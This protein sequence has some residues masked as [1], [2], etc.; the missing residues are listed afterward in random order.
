MKLARQF[1][2]LAVMLGIYASTGTARAADVPLR[3]GEHPTF[4]RVVFDWESTPDYTVERRDGQ[5]LIIFK[6]TASIKVAGR[7]NIQAINNISSEQRGSKLFVAV[8]LN[9]PIYGIHTFTSGTKVVVDMSTSATTNGAPLPKPAAAMEL[10]TSTASTP[11]APAPPKTI[12]PA[13][14]PAPTTAKPAAPLPAAAPSPAT[15]PAAVADGA[16]PPEDVAPTQTVQTPADKPKPPAAPFKIDVAQGDDALSLKF[17]WVQETGAAVFE[18]AG[19]VWLV[20]DQPAQ[21][22]V[23]DLLTK[24]GKLLTSAR[25]YSDPKFTILRLQLS[26]PLRPSVWRRGTSWNIDLRLQDVNPEVGVDLNVEPLAKP[27]PRVLL[28][29]PSITQVFRV[30]DPGVGD[31]VW[32]ATAAGVSYGNVL[33]RDLPNFQLLASAQGIAVVPK[34]AGIQASRTPEGIA[35]TSPDGLLVSAEAAKGDNAKTANAKVLFDYKAWAQV[36]GKKFYARKQS[37]QRAIVD[38]PK[39]RRSAKRMELAQFLFAHGFAAEAIGVVDVIIADDPQVAGIIPLKFLT[40]AGSF[41]QSFN[42]AAMQSF[43]DDRFAAYPEGKLWQAAILATAGDTVKATAAADSAGGVPATYPARIAVALSLPIAEA[44]IQQNRLDKAAVILDDLAVRGAT[45]AEKNRIAYTKGVLLH[46]KGKNFQARKLWENL[47]KTEDQWSRTRAEFSLTMLGLEEKKLSPK[48]AVAAFERLRYAWRGDG[49]EFKILQQLGNLYLDT[50]DYRRGLR[51]LQEAIRRFGKHPQKAALEKQMNDTFR[52]LYLEGG[53]DGVPPLTAL[54]LFDEFRGLTPNTP[55]GDQMI[56]NLADRL[57]GV[58]LLDRASDLL[59]HQIQE[60]LTGDNKARV[61]ARL[62]LIQLLDHDANGALEGLN[63]SNEPIA[64]PDLIRKRTYLRARALVMKDVPDEA[65]LLLAGDTTTRANE[66]RSEIMWAK[67]DFPKLI[68]ILDKMIAVKPNDT[69]ISDR[70][71]QYILS[72]ALAL[73]MNQDYDRL[74]NLKKDYGA[75]MR[76]TSYQQT[77]DLVA[78]PPPD[79]S[80]KSYN[81]LADRFAD[82]QSFQNFLDDYRQQLKT[83]KLSGTMQ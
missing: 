19:Y 3:L 34:S 8:D 16:Q 79:T 6:T 36:P 67:Q 75:L 13:P 7:S 10:N 14:Q 78:T 15:T 83:G 66:L 46:G 20:F 29:L 42:D 33:M 51:T 43:Q 80:L 30:L 50:K 70:Q 31:H 2:L 71:A 24:S 23:D 82:I 72:L 54:A 64:D 5:V 28:V 77:F 17:P 81:E 39:N 68:Q 69:T 9:R 63:L 27:L 52:L 56:Q 60:R 38:A 58:D 55:E 32:I 44:Y 59:K 62:A 26:K 76:Q 53:A 47:T 25:H 1:L 48:D 65:L 57:V 12:P 22:D 18:R 40:G 35:L 21:I 41:L 61:G 37:L 74:E 45:P 11:P 4:I 73:S 49:F